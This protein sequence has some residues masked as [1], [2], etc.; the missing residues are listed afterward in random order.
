MRILRYFCHFIVRVQAIC[1]LSTP[2]WD[3]STLRRW[4][5]E[6]WASIAKM[7]LLPDPERSGLN[8][9]TTGSTRN[10]I[11]RLQELNVDHP[12]ECGI[13]SWSTT[14]AKGAIT[15][16]RYWISMRARCWFILARSRG[17]SASAPG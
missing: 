1:T 2:P 17:A 7:L 14:K 6:L 10:A 9:V 16:R 4:R 12:W 13:I 3:R 15:P 8:V 5:V 11:G